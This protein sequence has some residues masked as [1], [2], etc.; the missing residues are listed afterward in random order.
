MVRKIKIRVSTSNNSGKYATAPDA[1]VDFSSRYEYVNA[2]DTERTAVRKELERLQNEKDRILQE[3]VTLSRKAS[4]K[5]YVQL[6]EIK[7]KIR[8]TD[9]VY[10]AAY[11]KKS[12]SLLKKIARARKQLDILND[13]LRPFGI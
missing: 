8:E 7:R 3:S 4:A 12:T 11:E 2:L 5:L 9:D 1:I 6:E 10:A 13:K